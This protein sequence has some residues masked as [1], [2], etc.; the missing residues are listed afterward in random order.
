[1]IR[2]VILFLLAFAR[3]E[4]PAETWYFAQMIDSG[5][6]VAFTMDGTV[7]PASIYGDWQFG[8][9]LDA[10]TV[11]LA[12]ALEGGDTGLYR[13]TPDGAAEIE[14]PGSVEDFRQP[15]AFAN[16]YVVLRQVTSPLPA[17]TLLINAATA[18][19]ELLTGALP[20]VARISADGA[21]LRYMST[22]GERWSLIE[23]T[24]ATGAERVAADFTSD[25]P[26]PLSS[27]DA[28][29]DRWIFET[30]EDRLSVFNLLTL[31]GVQTALDSGTRDQPLR[32]SFLNDALIRNSP[33]CDETCAFHVFRDSSEMILPLP[34][35]DFYQP[36][37]V[38]QPDRLLA[39][40]IDDDNFYLLNANA[41][42]AL[43]GDYDPMR[44]FMPAHQLISPDGRYVLTGGGA[45]RYA[46]WELTSGT[47][48]VVF[49]ARYVGLILYN[50]QGF[51]IHSYG[52]DADNGLAYRYADGETITL[53]HTAVGL[54]FDLLADGTLVYMLQQADD[55]IGEPGIYR[56]DPQSETYTPVLPNARLTYPQALG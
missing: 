44:I 10:S 26:L 31:D 27:A 41:S 12:I 23:R 28:H 2:A 40:N 21:S 9:R 13:V 14:L 5:E 37:A 8:L 15:L 34:T 54:Y 29:G 47:P 25:N 16:P 11:L 18:Q 43:L 7:H 36:F 33:I 3:L 42:Y 32:W 46:V 24:L 22:D 19:A 48:V 45:D 50:E 55:A 52:D 1:M 53:P 35:N 49:S 20:A 17:P 56:Y 39:L 6:V 51:L 4:Q 30:R 38:A